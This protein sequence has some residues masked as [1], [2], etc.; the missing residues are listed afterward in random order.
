MKTY[1]GFSEDFNNYILKVGVSGYERA[2]STQ[3]F[4]RTL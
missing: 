2:V 4:N 3:S 1:S